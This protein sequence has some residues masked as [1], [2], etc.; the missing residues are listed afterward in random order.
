MTPALVVVLVVAGAAGLFVLAWWSSG[1]SK[2]LRR[3]SG[4]GD[5][6]QDEARVWA[7]AQKTS[8]N[9]SAGGFGGT[10]F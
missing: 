7:N 6:R 8:R 9:E 10:P 2:G 3:R 5:A 4:D 1:R